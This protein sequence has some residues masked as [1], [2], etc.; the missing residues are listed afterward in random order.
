MQA[1]LCPPHRCYV[2]FLDASPQGLTQTH[3]GSRQT[4]PA[5][6]SVASWQF[7]S[8]SHRP[9]SAPLLCPPL[10]WCCGQR[11]KPAASDSRQLQG[12]LPHPP[13]HQETMGK[14]DRP[15]PLVLKEHPDMSSLFGSGRWLLNRVP[16]LPPELC[17]TSSKF[18]TK[19][20]VYFDWMNKGKRNINKRLT[21]LSLWFERCIPGEFL[22]DIVFLFPPKFN[23]VSYRE[24]NSK[25]LYSQYLQHR[26]EE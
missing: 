3:S 20:S 13:T 16:L 12:C 24:K 14:L 21:K 2:R 7:P 4:L 8:Q 9:V 6:P 1:S 26:W 15:L 19:P 5:M 11:R 23:L 25:H 10:H 17:S 18:Q 22:K